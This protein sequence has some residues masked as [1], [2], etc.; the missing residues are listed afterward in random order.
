[1]ASVFEDSTSVI[2]SHVAVSVRCPFSA[3]LSSTEVPRLGTTES[4]R[5]FGW[6]A[7]GECHTVCRGGRTD[8]RCVSDPETA[9]AL[10]TNGDGISVHA[11]RNRRGAHRNSGIAQMR[12]KISAVPHDR[13]VAWLDHIPDPA[14][15][16]RS[17]RS[18]TSTGRS[19]AVS[20]ICAQGGDGAHAASAFS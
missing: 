13:P 12:R 9:W 5:L 1:M 20:E 14:P 3:G 18:G 7:G 16:L 6:F 15:G 8:G 2:R 4:A 17:N 10:P 11:T 19:K